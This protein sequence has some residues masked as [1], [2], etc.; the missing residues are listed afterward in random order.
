MGGSFYSSDSRSLRAK[1]LGYTTKSADEI[2]LQNRRARIH[3][4]MMPQKALLREAR[5]SENHP[6]SVPIV[7]ALDVTGSMGHIPHY[8]VKEGLP[9]L[10]G[11]MIQ[12]GVLDPQ[13]LFLPIG[14]HECDHYPLQVGQFESGDE[15]LD[16]WLTRTFIEGGGG[17]NAGR[18]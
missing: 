4:S 5:D 11:S 17:G 12:R 13:V 8:L 3:E 1:T 18:L 10:M 6:N 14:D 2:F 9:N 7:F 15:E 16:I